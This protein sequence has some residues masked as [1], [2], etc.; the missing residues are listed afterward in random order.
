[1]RY[2]HFG[3]GAYETTEQAIRTLLAEAGDDEWSAH[4]RRVGTG[5]PTPVL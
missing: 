5:E 3:E 2:V 1:V 4:L